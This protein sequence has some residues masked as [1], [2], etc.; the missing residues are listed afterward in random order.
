MKVPN[1]RRLTGK[2]IESF[3]FYLI[4]SS[5]VLLLTALI[6]YP[7]YNRWQDSMDLGRAKAET[8]KIL[9]AINSVHS[10]GDIGSVQQVPLT[11][12][13]SYSIA[14]NNE[15]VRVLKH[16]S[17]T[18]EYPLDVSLR[19]RG[20]V[21]LTGEGRYLLTLVYWTREDPSNEGKEFLLE[22]LDP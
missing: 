3:P 2:G 14:F 9:T 12:P 5:I 6:V 4:L 20:T 8:A 7:A 19:Y 13:E 15:S 22:V 10:M 17:S 1:P 11:I 16:N 18:E 21:N